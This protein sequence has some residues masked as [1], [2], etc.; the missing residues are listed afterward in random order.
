MKQE[1]NINCSVYAVGFFLLTNTLDYSPLLWMVQK[2][3]YM[4]GLA[5]K[6]RKILG[7]HDS[8]YQG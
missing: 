5:E 4:I 1:L 6:E 3:L 2:K 8:L 7:E